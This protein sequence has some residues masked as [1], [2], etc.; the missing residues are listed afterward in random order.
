M[1]S[2]I[3]LHF[4]EAERN[5]GAELEKEDL[6]DWYLENELNLMEELEVENSHTWQNL[7]RLRTHFDSKN[8]LMDI[9]S[10]RNYLIKMKGD[11]QRTR[12]V[13]YDV[14]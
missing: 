13:V 4:S 9:F 2:L 6:I 3:V 11:V 10:L 14:T 8:V 7:S 5:T 1:Q 12:P